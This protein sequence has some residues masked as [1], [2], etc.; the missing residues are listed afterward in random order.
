VRGVRKRECEQNRPDARKNFAHEGKIEQRFNVNIARP[1]R[2]RK[3]A[4]YIWVSD[5]YVVSIRYELTANM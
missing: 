5:S 3:I 2:S 4:L 1:M